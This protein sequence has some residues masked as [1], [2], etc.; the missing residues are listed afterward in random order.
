MFMSRDGDKSGV[1]QLELKVV[2]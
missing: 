1:V 2:L